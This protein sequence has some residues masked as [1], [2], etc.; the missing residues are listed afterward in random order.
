M[1][2]SLLLLDHATVMAFHTLLVDPGPLGLG[3]V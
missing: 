2:K 3:A 1:P